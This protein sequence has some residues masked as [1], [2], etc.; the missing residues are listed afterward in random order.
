MKAGSFTRAGVALILLACI[1]PP[2]P[3]AAATSQVTIGVNQN[4]SAY[5][6]APDG[7]GPYPGVVVLHTS[8]GLDH[9]DMAFAEQLGRAG[10]VCLVPA[11]M[12]AYRISGPQRA[13]TFTTYHD[14]IYADLADGVDRLRRLDKVAGHKIG[15]VGFS[16]GGYWAAA[17]AAAG[18]VEAGVS[19][20]GVLSGF[21]GE[22]RRHLKESVTATSSPILILH[23]LNDTIQTVDGARFL[24]RLLAAVS[25]RH[26][27][28]LYPAAGHQFERDGQNADVASDAWQRTL[29]FY[30]TYLQ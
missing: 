1:D 5:L 17:L 18:K 15:A 23:G 19:Y 30:K 13:A 20:Y 26:D 27:M 3:A 28:H 25:V 7:P 8:S 6:V 29:A 4:M 14:R 12:A 10:Y 22:M 24:D 2:A 11:F 16:N 9:A 21:G